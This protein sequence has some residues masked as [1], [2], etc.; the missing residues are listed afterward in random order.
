MDKKA[1]FTIISILILALL[2]SGAA[3][4][5]LK[6][7]TTQKDGEVSASDARNIR[8]GTDGLVMTFVKGAPPDQVYSTEGLTLM[9]NL[10]N[11]GA[12]SIQDARF[13]I[14][15]I[16]PNIISFGSDTGLFAGAGFSLSEFGIANLPGK[17]ELM[18]EF[19]ESVI[20]FNSAAASLPEGIDIYE[21]DIIVTTCYKYRTIASPSVCVDPNPFGAYT[22]AKV[23]KPLSV[24]EAGGQGGPIV[25]TRVDQVP[26]RGKVQFKIYVENRGRGKAISN[27]KYDSCNRIEP[28]DYMYINKIDFYS[29]EIGGSTA[30]PTCQPDPQGLRLIDEKGVIICSFTVPDNNAAYT[31]PLKIDLEYNY[32]ESTIPKRVRIIRI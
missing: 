19:G 31:T 2:V 1:Y 25:V 24:T 27:E 16:D 8:S 28:T 29:V 6:K 26:S 9:L 4:N 7:A 17:S 18:G 10:Q 21:P 20:T 14:G 32:M 22:A 11:K 23:C 3:C 15:G 5:P 13:Y 12:E 30:S